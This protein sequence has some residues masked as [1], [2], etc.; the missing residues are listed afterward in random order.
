MKAKVRIYLC[1]TL[2]LSL[3]HI[4][5][6]LLG[7]GV[8]TPKDQ[9]SAQ[10]RFQ[11]A[12]HQLVASARATALAKQICPEIQIGCMAASAPRY[13][14]TCDPQDMIAMMTSQQELDYFIH[15]H[16]T[17]EYPYYAKRLWRENNVCLEITER[18]V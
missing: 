16:C 14:M 1:L 10:D 6:P 13:P 17:G 18:C 3:I 8:M 4:F 2:S 7:A 12:H 15:V 9:L 11:T 5:S